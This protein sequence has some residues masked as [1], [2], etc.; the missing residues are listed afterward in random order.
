MQTKQSIARRKAGIPPRQLMTHDQ[1]WQSFAMRAVMF[2]K[3]VGAL[4]DLDKG[5]IECVDCDA[6]AECYDHRDYAR[7]LDVSPVCMGC[8]ARR[9]SACIPEPYIEQPKRKAA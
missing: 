8:N 6:A 9:G 7:P 2:A 4:P 5:N 3:S 1:R